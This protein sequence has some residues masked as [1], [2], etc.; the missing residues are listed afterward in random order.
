MHALLNG[1]DLVGEEVC[2]Y[3]RAWFPSLEQVHTSMCACVLC[4][5]VCAWLCVLASLSFSFSLSLSLSLSLV[6]CACV[7]L[8]V[9]GWVGRWVVGA[10][11]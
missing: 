8:C 2:K 3:Q 11:V 5:S 4:V 1:L 7:C 10:C 6:P 9:C